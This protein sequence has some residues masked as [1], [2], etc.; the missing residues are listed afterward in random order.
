MSGTTKAAVMAARRAAKAVEAA[1]AEAAGADMAFGLAF[2]QGRRI[3]GL[4]SR[5]WCG[6]R[7]QRRGCAGRSV[8]KWSFA[9]R[10][11]T[12][13]CRPITACVWFGRSRRVDTGVIFPIR[14]V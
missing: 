8:G 4:N 11:W 3:F 2:P 7:A 13:W 14:A 10:A 1:G 9:R 6:R 5:P 12:S